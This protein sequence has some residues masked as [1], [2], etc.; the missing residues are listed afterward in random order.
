MKKLAREKQLAFYKHEG[1]WYCMD[2]QKHA[3]ELNRLWVKG[4]APW[5]IWDKN[6]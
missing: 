2:T 5:S 3:D 6:A 4:L 1:F